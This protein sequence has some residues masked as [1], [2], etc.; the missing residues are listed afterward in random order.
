MKIV[1]GPYGYRGLILKTRKI[2]HFGPNF[3]NS[4]SPEC[5][6]GQIILNYLTANKLFPVSSPSTFSSIPD[7]SFEIENMLSEKHNKFCVIWNI[8]FAFFYSL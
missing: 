2:R 3:G 1:A 6:K 5:R 8:Q 7:I 4:Y